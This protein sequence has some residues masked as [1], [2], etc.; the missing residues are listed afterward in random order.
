MPVTLRSLLDEGPFRLRLVVPPG[1]AAVLDTPIAW[2]HSS[3]FPD[4]TPWLE[5]GQLLLTDGAHFLEHRDARAAEGYVERLVAR[6]ILALG[7]ATG[8]LHETIPGS[9]VAACAARGFPLVDVAERTPFMAIIRHIADARAAEERGRLEWSLAAQ[10]AVALAALRPNGLDAILAEL[11]RRL[12][13]WATLYDAAGEPSH[14]SPRLR[15]PAAAAP[16][17]QRAVRQ[18]L[19]RGLRSS[20]RLDVDGAGVTVQTIGNRGQLRGALA[21]APAAPLDVAADEL[22]TSVIALAS[23]ALEQSH[24]LQSARDD[25][26]SA[27]LELLIAGELGTAR[28]TA[29]RLDLAL[30]GEVPLRV[31]ATAADGR[32]VS[33]WA[34]R[35]AAGTA[36][37]AAFVADRGALTVVVAADAAAE[38]V[39]EALTGQGRAVAVSALESW[40]GLATALRQVRLL[41][42]E[43]VAPASVRRF[44]AAADERLLGALRR[45]GG[46]LVAQR[47]LAPLGGRGEE[48]RR[49]LQSARVWLGHNGAYD[50]AARELGIHRHTL[51]MRMASLG[52]A[53]GLDLDRFG[54]RAELWAALQ[55][56]AEADAEADPEA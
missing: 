54:D 56:A 30:P 27:L 55:L 43:G 24:A 20:V 13:G 26:R 15:M 29:E 37:G 50:P 16:R 2:A 4:P 10:R 23:I 53:L 52:R 22:L 1:E 11:E 7:F 36:A 9:V 6:G 14:A 5:P 39:A 34:S 8:I 3:D 47:L 38:A 25:L 19:G 44:D 33:A 45:G 32:P 46:D 12:D 35:L 51:R 49:L 41:L 21:V 40:S 28:R 18:A 48:G 31:L 17:V 42:A